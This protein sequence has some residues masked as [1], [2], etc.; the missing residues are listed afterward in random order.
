[1]EIVAD[2][3]KKFS[4]TIIMVLHDINHARLYSDEVLII[5]DKKIFA[6][7]EP[8]KILSAQTVSAV[9]NVNVDT[10]TNATGD[11]IIFPTKKIL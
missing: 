11:E 1:M 3:N 9:F 5:H 6:S 2:V 8:K 10:F 4:T 7:G